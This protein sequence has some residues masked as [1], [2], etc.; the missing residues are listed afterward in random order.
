MLV[1]PRSRACWEGNHPRGVPQPGAR[2]RLS[3]SPSSK[4]GRS[5]KTRPL[6]GSGDMQEGA[7]CPELDAWSPQSNPHL[8]RRPAGGSSP[9]QRGLD[10]AKWGQLPLPGQPLQQTVGLSKPS[11]PTA[12]TRKQGPDEDPRRP[13]SSPLLS[14]PRQCSRQ[15]TPTSG[16][17]SRQECTLRT[18]PR[19]PASNGRAAGSQQL[20]LHF[21]HHLSA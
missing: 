6:P 10:L 8:G 20:C 5:W 21:R 9:K 3:S 2:G 16:A 14:E 13:V 4:A 7:E 1:P 15:W 17:V 12:P 19:G 18:L 11:N